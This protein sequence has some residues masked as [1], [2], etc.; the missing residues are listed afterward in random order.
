M[1]AGHYGRAPFRREGA[2]DLE[3]AAETD[4]ARYQ[5]CELLDDVLA[6]LPE[7]HRLRLSS[8]EPEDVTDQLLEQL[9]HPR[10]C[11]HLHMPLQSGCDIVLKAMRR[12]YSVA[13]YLDIV[14]RFRRACPRGALTTDILVGYPTESGDD[15][16]AT[17]RLCTAAG[18]ERIHGFPFSQRPGTP[19][20]QLTPLPRT[21]VRRR[22]RQLIAH[23]TQ[24][25]DQRWQRFVGSD[26]TLIVE[27]QADGML[28]GHGEAY[29]IVQLPQQPDAAELIGQCLPVRLASYT[30]GIFTG[31]LQR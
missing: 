13:Q 29:Q 31:E 23:C 16:D 9:T 8:I 3:S 21:E 18:F 30:N 11:P 17:L 28:K 15:F 6:V 2:A 14:S 5:L 4:R 10:M 24:I 12:H 19:A 25:A 26:C 20:A 22:N 7:G 1:N 27:E